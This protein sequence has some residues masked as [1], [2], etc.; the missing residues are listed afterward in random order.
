MHCLCTFFTIACSLQFFYPATFVFGMP[1]S[2]QY[3]TSD[4]FVLITT[5]SD[6][7]CDYKF[8]AWF[9]KP[10]MAFIRRRESWV[11]K[12]LNFNFQ[13]FTA[14]RNPMDRYPSSVFTAFTC[15]DGDSYWTFYVR[16]RF[17]LLAI[18]GVC[19]ARPGNW[20]NAAVRNDTRV[21]R[22]TLH[23]EINLVPIYRWSSR[24]SS[25]RTIW[26]AHVLRRNF[27]ALQFIQVRMLRVTM[28]VLILETNHREVW[29]VQL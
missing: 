10:R 11:D 4:T 23:R 26:A 24:A 17:I 5:H 7:G 29:K 13:N 16:R 20:R 22:W 9:L 2:A 18:S 12:T 27:Q 14:K 19:Q 8:A 15:T 3:P 28:D 1:T 6:F 25:C 21:P